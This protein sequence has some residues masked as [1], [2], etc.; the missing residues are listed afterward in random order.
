MTR[1]LIADDHEI[2]RTGLRLMLEGRGGWTVVAEA[3]DGRAAIAR[4]IEL[5]PD[6]AVVDYSLPLFNGVEVTRQIRARRPEVEVLIF[7]M[8]ESDSLVEDMLDAGARGYLL[9]SDAAQHLITAVDLLSR[10]QPFF[11][12]KLSEKLLSHFLANRPHAQP[13]TLTTRE[14]MIVQLVAEGHTNREIGDI[15][16]LSVKTVETHRA[17]ALR[18]LNLT[19]TASLV[20]Y[21]IRNRLVEP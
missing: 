15:L 18:R 17:A 9:K 16:N 5:Q 3:S 14:R 7:T 12:G 1:I 19:S 4:A 13:Q 21:A 8:H 11:T 6:V 20:R 2:V 10:H